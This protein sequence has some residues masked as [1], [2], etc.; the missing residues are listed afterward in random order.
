[1]QPR[2]LVIILPRKPQ[3]QGESASISIRVLVGPADAK[4]CRVPS[5]D[6]YALPVGDDSRGVQVIGVDEVD[7]TGR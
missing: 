4:G 6:F 2:L 3:I 1:M 5:P 7:V